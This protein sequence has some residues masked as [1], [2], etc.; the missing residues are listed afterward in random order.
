M[1]NIS[2]N[3][4][5]C[6]AKS[7][8]Y[9]FHFNNAY[10]KSGIPYTVVVFVS[11]FKMSATLSPLTT[12]LPTELQNWLIG[13]TINILITGKTGV[14]KSALVNSLMGAK[15]APEGHELKP[16]TMEVTSYTAQIN[17]VSIVIWDSPGL[18]DGSYNEEKY[19]EDMKAKCRSYDLVLYCTRMNE[20][21]YPTNDDLNA[22]KS[23]T[24]HFGQQ[25][26]E[27]AVYVLTFANEVLPSKKDPNM[28][29][30]RFDQLKSA[31]PEVMAVKC[32]VTDATSIPI[33]AA[34]YIN[35]DGEGRKLPPLT[36]DWLSALWYTTVLKMKESAQP[37]MLVAN[38]DRITKI[39]DSD[40]SCQLLS[41]SKSVRQQIVYSNDLRIQDTVPIMKVLGILAQRSLQSE[42]F[43]NCRSVGELIGKAIG[44][45]VKGSGGATLGSMIGSTAGAAV[46]FAI[47][48]VGEYF[49]H[50]DHN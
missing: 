41:Q 20:T 44:A 33:V 6:R 21:R 29:R 5:H 9:E 46:G 30:T 19:I 45:A 16:Q 2:K 48:M 39:D 8:N 43:S 31:I 27:N 4:I 34:G 40:T 17:G 36:S 47:A 26:W 14:G 10:V 11:N 22:V 35:E 38:I 23:L 18:Q 50:Q 28:M 32:G 25:L 13:K 49:K 1:I 15:I 7:F 3:T 42:T 12:E 37:A 24:K